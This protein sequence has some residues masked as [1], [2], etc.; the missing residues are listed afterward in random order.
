MSVLRNWGSGCAI[1]EER[2]RRG[3]TLLKDWKRRREVQSE[4]GKERKEKKRGDKGTISS[5]ATA[6]CFACYFVVISAGMCPTW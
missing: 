2:I 1:M 3:V 4:R 5:P 6:L